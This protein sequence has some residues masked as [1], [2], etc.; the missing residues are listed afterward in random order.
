MKNKLHIPVLL[1]VLTIAVIT[2]FQAYWLKKNYQEEK[3]LFEIH[4]NILFRET[5]FRLQASKLKLDSNFN[6]KVR[7]KEGVVSMVNVLRNKL[8]DSITVTS[9]PRTSGGM[10][11][12]LNQANTING[13]KRLFIKDTNVA[14]FTR[15]GPGPD[16][17]GNPVLDF[18]VGV[19]SLQDSITVKEVVDSY[20]KELRQEKINVP[21]NVTV[22]KLPA[23]HSMIPLSEPDDNTVTMGF[24]KPV[25]YTLNFE[26]SNWY[27]LKKLSQPIIISCLLV[28]VTIFSFLLMYRNIVR[29]RNLT[30]LKNDFISNITHELKT[31]IATVSVAIEALRNF[32]ALDDPRRTREYLDISANELQRLSLLVDKVLKLSMFE[33]KEIELK[34]ELFD[35]KELSAEVIGTMRLLFDKHRAVVTFN[36]TGDNFMIEADKLHLTSVIYNLLDNALKYSKENPVINVDLSLLPND[37]LE[38]KVNDNGIGIPHEYRFKIFTKFFR[39]PTGDKHN[40]KGYGLGLSY[41]SEVI[42][43]HMGFIIVESELGKGS[44][45]IVKVPVKEADV[46]YFD[47]HR[48]IRMEKKYFKL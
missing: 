1:M 15:R 37:I 27:L 45:F 17:H 33:K 39:V 19:D 7:Q 34:K 30:Q 9:K 41:V 28:G 29:Q 4:T 35:L 10:V 20:A 6:I 8:T 23:Q 44:T 25:T 46:I 22:H 14:Y 31:P 11:I 18:L 21:F 13:E 32:N 36:A 48:R 3:R 16:I 5:V 47:E 24:A 40:I 38:L 12:A 26:N 2:V 43:R 42:K